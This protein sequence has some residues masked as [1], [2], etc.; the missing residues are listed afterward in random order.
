MIERLKWN[1][2]RVHNTS[3][4]TF[5]AYGIAMATSASF[6]TYERSNTSLV[7]RQFTNNSS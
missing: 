3:V 1:I 5:D 7:A 6:Y 2:G 4:A